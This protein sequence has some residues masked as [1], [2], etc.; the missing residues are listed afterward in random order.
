MAAPDFV[1][2][3]EGHN[4]GGGHVEVTVETSP[5]PQPGQERTHPEMTGSDSDGNRSNNRCNPGKPYRLA[6][7]LRAGLLQ[8]NQDY[9]CIA[10]SRPRI[11]PLPREW[12]KTGVAFTYACCS[13][14]VTTVMI[15]V[16]HERVPEQ[17]HAPPLPD[18]VFDHVG[19]VPWAFTVTEVSG[20]VLVSVLFVQWLVLKYK[21]IVARRFFFLQ[22]TLYLYRIVT[23]YVTTL[24]APGEHMT[25]AAKLYGDTEG[26]A[27]RVATLL[28]GGGLSI[29]GS[30][31]LCGDYLF[32]G[33][34]VMLTLTF[35]FIREYSPRSAWGWWFYH[36]TCWLLSVVGVVCILLAHEHYS[37][38]V[39][40]AY[41]VTSRIFYWYHTMANNQALRSSPQNY[42]SRIWWN[43]AFNFLERNV[44]AA[45][46]PT[47]SWPV[48][49]PTA[50]LR[51]QCRKY[52]AVRDAQEERE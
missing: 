14:V 20:V 38:D 6:R 24:P 27:R 47:F 29:T 46:P 16:V 34:T 42:L 44:R 35:L 5:Q 45:V 18:K 48:P 7:T 36:M 17:S 22:G 30:H 3:G 11:D 52:S 41:F 50:W 19:R 39:V 2:E 10:M 37:V 4:V 21:A 25:C 40:V 23:M 12:W 8:R 9:I 26:M 28:S 13:L 31:V 51:N 33:H 15:T 1:E 49:L 43:P 32:S